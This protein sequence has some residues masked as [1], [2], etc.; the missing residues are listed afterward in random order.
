MTVHRRWDP[1]QAEACSVAR[2]ALYTAWNWRKKICCMCILLVHFQQ[3]MC[4][5]LPK[6]PSLL[7][8]VFAA[9]PPRPCAREHT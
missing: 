1:N 8:T 5:V 4:R 3:Q 2:F 6:P 7:L 9:P